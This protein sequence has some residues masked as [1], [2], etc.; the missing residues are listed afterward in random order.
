MALQPY[1]Y[2]ML[3]ALAYAM[4]CGTSTQD[5]LDAKILP[6]DAFNAPELLK[7]GRGVALTNLQATFNWAPRTFAV[8][9]QLEISYNADFSQMIP[10]S[11]FIVKAPIAS[12]EFTSTNKLPKETK[13]YWRVRTNL[14]EAGQLKSAYSEVRSF[15]SLDSTIYVY[16]PSGI[17]N[18]SDASSDGTPE[19]PY[20]T[21]AGAMLF[22]YQKDVKNVKVAARNSGSGSYKESITLLDGINLL[23]GYKYDSVAD[24][25]DFSESLRNTT[26]STSGNR[27]IIESQGSIG[28]YASDIRKATTLEGFT[29]TTADSNRPTALLI[30]GSDA[31]F[32]IKNN[33]FK[34]GVPETS[35]YGIYA[36]DCATASGPTIQNNAVESNDT[37]ANTGTSNIGIYTNNC[38]AT[39]ERNFVNLAPGNI[40]TT[41]IQVLNASPIINNNVVQVQAVAAV[42]PS[43]SAFFIHTTDASIASAPDITNNTAYVYALS[44][45][46]V[47]KHYGVKISS[48]GGLTGGPAKL[49]NNIICLDERITNRVGI[50]EGSDAF[51]S[52]TASFANNLIFDTDGDGITSAAEAGIYKVSSSAGYNDSTN[53]TPAITY[54]TAPSGGQGAGTGNITLVGLPAL[55]NE[56]HVFNTDLSSLGA[57][58]T[59]SDFVI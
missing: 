36:E 41:G 1:R 52:I 14:D 31:D 33:T 24:K 40:F 48:Q 35:A 17:S 5:L 19:N 53:S 21:I 46:A 8:T 28:V 44:A 39:I 50:Y 11:P 7:P 54:A 6:S 3:L 34:A 43:A 18:C 58:P 16:C 47:G 12:Y 57:A 26:G 37:S 2:I 55:Q 38:K 49:D 59:V 22:A 15:I 10:G 42:S 45:L 9:Y 13:Y 23:G 4:R 30:N 32:V 20:Q 29:I 51:N 25:A 56:T 27:T